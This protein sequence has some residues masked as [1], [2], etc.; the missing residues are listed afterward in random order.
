MHDSDTT[1]F[2]L[3]QMLDSFVRER[4]WMKYH[5][6]KELAT[7]IIVEAAEL[8]ENFQW[9]TEEEIAKQL[10]VPEFKGRV[11]NE[12]ADVLA[13][14]L[15]MANR[16]DLDLA[17]SFAEKMKRNMSRFPPDVYDGFYEHGSDGN[18]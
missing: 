16:L 7:A 8:A 11:A 17:H 18:A 3:R 14:L 1:V 13:F 9:R 15:G 6:P 4:N 2:E 5:S 10:D 12:M